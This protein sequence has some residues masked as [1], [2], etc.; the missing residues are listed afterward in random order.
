MEFTLDDEQRAAVKSRDVLAMNV[1][2]LQSDDVIAPGKN[3]LA[4]VDDD[5]VT[6]KSHLDGSMH[7]FSPEISMRIQ[8]QLGAD[9]IFWTP[10]APWLKAAAK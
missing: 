3:R 10:Q 5:G 6:F 4:T 8:H 2:G 7:R 9:I 1:D